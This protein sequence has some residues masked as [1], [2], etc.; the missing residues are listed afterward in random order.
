LGTFEADV[1]AVDWEDIAIGPG[2][3]DDMHYLYI[4]DTGDN[5]GSREDV[6]VFRV[7]EPD[8]AADQSPVSESLTGVATL[9]F[10]Y[11]DGARDTET[12]IVDPDTGDLYFVSKRDARSRIYRADAPQSTI[13]VTTLEFVGELT[14]T[15]ASAGDISPS[16]RELILKDL[17]RVYYYARPEGMSIGAALTAEPARLPY[18]SEPLGE[19]LSFDADGSGYFTHS[20][21]A[22]QP[23]YYYE[24]LST[25]ATADLNGDGRVDR[26]DVRLLAMD[27]GGTNLAG[28]S[29]ADLNGD[30]NVDLVDLAAM[31]SQISVASSAQSALAQAGVEINGAATA[32]DANGMRATRRAISRLERESYP[33]IQALDREFSTWSL[34]PDHRA[35]RR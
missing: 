34:D 8:V 27:F 12:L 2:P 16:G 35:R 25:P 23:L 28:D 31:Q 21:G 24:R 33:S 19:G 3:V 32:A 10:R 9:R 13:A 11:P 30:G 14:W 7:A 5:S 26:L 1:A 22:N 18:R 20:E 17:S 15:A 6:A 4:A 29:I